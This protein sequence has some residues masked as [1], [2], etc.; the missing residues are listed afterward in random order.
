[1]FQPASFL[2]STNL[3]PDAIQP[4]IEKL[5]GE[6]VKYKMAAVCV[7]PYRLATAR[8]IVVGTGVNLCAV[9]GFPLGA[10]GMDSKVYTAAWA[11]DN[12]ADELDMVMNLG[13]W[14][15]KDLAT[16]TG[17]IEGILALKKQYNFIFKLIVETALLDE[18]ELAQIVKILNHSGVDYIK[19]STGFAARGVSLTDLEIIKKHKADSLKIKAAG[20]IRDWDFALALI[21]AGADRLGT[22]SAGKL[23]EEY[24][25]KASDSLAT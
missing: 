7:H 3:R 22:S 23:L 14:K 24:L 5:C 12:G 1:M 19:T 6:A 17:E 15:D 20:G 2:E 18:S 11:L 21:E 9:I 10:E 4:D 8:S 16:V 25:A 13:A